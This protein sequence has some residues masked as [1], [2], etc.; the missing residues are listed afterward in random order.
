LGKIQRAD[1]AMAMDVTDQDLAERLAAAF[2]LSG[3]GSAGAH[4]WLWRSL[5]QL[6]ARGE[7]VTEDELAMA[8]ARPLAEVRAALSVLPDTEY[9][10]EGRIIGSGITLRPTPHRFEIDGHTLYTWCALDTLIF[11]VVLG[12]PARVTSRCRSTGES[13]HVEVGPAGLGSVAPEDAVISLVMPSPSCSIRGGFCDEVHF[14]ASAALAQA[15][16]RDH[17][18]G[19][20]CPVANAFGVARSLADALLAREQS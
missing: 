1:T 8:T 18:E 6:L 3:S 7:P 2:T 19:T 10:E 15:W 14:F 13:I 9:D 4:P 5:L 17:P 11:P 16:L 12:R 20:V